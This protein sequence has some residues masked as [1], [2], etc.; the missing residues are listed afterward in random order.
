MKKYLLIILLV[1]LF[2]SAEVPAGTYFLMDNKGYGVSGEQTHFCLMDGNC[3]TVSGEFSFK[4]EVAGVST[5]VATVEKPYVP[6]PQPVD[7]G[8]IT[9]SQTLNTENNI[10][11]TCVNSYDFTNVAIKGFNG[12]FPNGTL[13]FQGNIQN[14]SKGYNYFA[15]NQYCNAHLTCEFIVNKSASEGFLLT[16]YLIQLPHQGLVKK[17]F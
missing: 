10:L 5:P 16:E 2:A 6:E 13:T 7:V 8:D 3:Y 4:R 11:I 9:C 1:P 17:G 12:Y 15:L 14:F